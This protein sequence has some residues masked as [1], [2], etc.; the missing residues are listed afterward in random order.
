MKVKIKKSS[1]ISLAIAFS[2]VF[3]TFTPI[4]SYAAEMKGKDVVLDG[5]KPSEGQTPEGEQPSE[6]QTPEGEQPSEGQTPEGEQPSEGQTPEG[7]QPS[8]GQTP[9]GEQPSEGQTPEGEQPSEGQTPEGEQP[10]EGQTPEGEQP[11]EGQTPEG[12][13]PSDEQ[14]PEEELVVEEMNLKQNIE[15]ILDMTLSQITKIVYNF[16][17]DEESVKTDEQS[18]IRQVL[19]SKDQN[20]HLWYDKKAK[21]KNTCLLKEDGSNRPYY[22]IRFD[23]ITKTLTF[24][25]IVEGLR[26]ASTK[27]NKYIIDGEDGEQ[28]AFCYNNHLKAPTS[29]GKS[30]YLPAEDF[31]GQENKNE[32]AIKSIIYAGSE[33]DGFG[34]KQQFNLGGEENEGAVYSA[35]QSAIWIM[36]GQVDEQA[37]LKQY[38]GSINFYDILI[39][40]AK[41]EEEKVE[42][43]KGKEQAINI[44]AY[45][46]ALLDAGHKQLKP[47]DTGKPSLSNGSTDIKFDKNEDGTYETEAIALVG[48]SGVVKLRLPKGVTAYDEEGNIIGT[49][50]VEVST[51]HKFKLK[52]VEKPDSKANISAVSY[53]YI[54][55]KAIQYYK[56]V[57]D[58]GE[59]DHSSLLPASK[60]NLLSYTIEQKNGEEVNFNIGLPTDGG[61]DVNP[62][63]PPTDDTVNPPV[64]PS[65]GGDSNGHKPSPPTDDTVINPPVPPADDTVINPPV[66]P[67]DDTVINPPVPPTDDTVVNPPVPPSGDTVVDTSVPPTDDTVINPPVPPTDDI[68]VKSPKTGDETQIMS[69]VFIGIIAICGLGYH[70]KRAKN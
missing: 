14:T 62:P 8:E 4:V 13:Q 22:D 11:S 15:K 27:D 1:I 58:F 23:D 57:F 61:S 64:P 17:E 26:G 39:E 21:V 31:N 52:S 51:Q 59:K 70:C 7:E 55:P 46:E 20:L 2:M 54:F 53:D 6:G 44:K 43:Q 41:T 66:P 3:A 69:Y 47:D 18:E 5:E 34:Y 68:V 19:T 9:E 45:L 36:L 56:S 25:Y 12:E 33:F 38:Q 28:T 63:V 10:S 40:S 29:D 49:G 67:T 30:P 50:E 35:T 32:D 48:Y 65:G 24:D 42:Y 60:Q 37:K 16:W